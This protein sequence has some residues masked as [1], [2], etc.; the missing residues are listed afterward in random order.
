MILNKLLVIGVSFILTLLGYIAFTAVDLPNIRQALENGIE[1]SQT[2]Q[3]LARDKSMIMAYGRYHHKPIHLDQVPQFCIDALLAT[4]DRRFYEHN[5]V[6]PVGILRALLRDLQMRRMEEGGST[7]TQ[8]LARN[9]FLSRERSLARKVKEALLAMKLETQ[10]NK[11]QILELYFNNVYF[12]E[13]A[14][15]IAAASDVYFGK[16]AADLSQGECALI[17]G[18][19]QAPSFYSPFS[20]LAPAMKRRT[21]VLQNLVEVGKISESLA[22]TYANE[23]LSLNANG[24]NLS[25]ANKAP[26]FNQYVIQKVTDILGID[27]QTFWQQ[28]VRVIT[29][30]DTRAQSLAESA[31]QNTSRTYGRTRKNQQA[32]LFSLNSHGEIIA[33]VGGKNYSQSQFDRIT[34]AKRQAGSLFKALLYTAAIENGYHPNTVY[35]DSAVQF[36]SWIPQNYDKAHHGY[37]T[38]ARA[39]SKSNNVIAVKLLNDLTPAKVIDLARRMGITSAMQDNL[40]LALGASEMTLFEMTEAFSVLTNMGDHIEPFGIQ[41]I[42]DRNG[43]VLYEHSLSQKNVLKRSVRDTMVQMMQGVIK[44]GTGQAANFGRS[45]AGKTGTSDEYRDAWF[46]GY[47]PEMTTGVWVGN[48]DSSVMPGVT[49]GSIPAR[50]WRSYMSRLMAGLPKRTFD[51]SK[52]QPIE[53]KDF[54]TFSL[55]NLSSSEKAGGNGNPV[56]ENAVENAMPEEDWNAAPEPYSFENAPEVAPLPPDPAEDTTQDTEEPPSAEPVSK[57]KP[58]NTGA[59]AIESP[60]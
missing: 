13:G 60:L 20:N 54:F 59:K 27:E 48:D 6:D 4:E 22:K 10:L 30:L 12:G 26:Y 21:E 44:F 23:P 32:S 46:V 45:M 43:A 52:A 14:Y 37:M 19:P 41:S 1:P 3:I 36:G 18:L 57:V 17:A 8:Q 50:I 34:Q 29:T 2:S 35:K 25:N 15:G 39:L 47:T 58:S 31:V 7:L 9:V 53:E 51:L 16:K 38:L 11:E 56:A 42:V 40:S 5:G 28:G 33:Y 24:K 55:E 49:G